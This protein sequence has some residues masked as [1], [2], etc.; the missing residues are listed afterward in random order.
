M[1]GFVLVGLA[2]LGPALEEVGEEV[3]FFSSIE[4]KVVTFIC[5][6]CYFS[7]IGFKMLMNKLGGGVFFLQ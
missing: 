5:R 3:V 4:F 6:G 2:A 7:S 1:H